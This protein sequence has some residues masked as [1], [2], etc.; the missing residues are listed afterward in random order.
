MLSHERH[1]EFP[2]ANE[3]FLVG[4]SDD[5]AC[6]DRGDGGHDGVM[7]RSRDDHNF[8]V[9]CRGRS[10]QSLIAA[11]SF[12]AVREIMFR[13]LPECNEVRTVAL[14][15][16]AEKWCVVPGGESHDTEMIR[17]IGN[18]LECLRPDGARRAQDGNADRRSVWPGG[19]RMMP[20][21]ISRC[22]TKAAGKAKS[23]AS[24]RSSIPP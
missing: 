12:Y 10:Q 5:F 16:L 14:D 24:T 8:N 22:M 13:L 6:L 11:D 15:L 1:D 19:H 21:A 17:M 7:S 2:S 9:S 23:N 20:S 4:Q 3:R 18:D